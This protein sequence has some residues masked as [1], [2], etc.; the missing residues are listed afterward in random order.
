MPESN[1]EQ[2]G[3]SLRAARN[4][5][6][7]TQE[8]LSDLSHVSIKHIA[9]IEKGKMN[10]SYEVLRALVTVLKISFDALVYPEMESEEEACKALSASYLSC[11]LTMRGTLLNSTR[12]LADELTTLAQ[13][14]KIK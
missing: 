6:G 8:Q 2:L 7:L 4:N 1:L 12:A 3:A 14:L 10:P 5:A 13:S 9:N 11:P